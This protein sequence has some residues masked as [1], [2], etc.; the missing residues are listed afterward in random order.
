MDNVH[1][2]N[3]RDFLQFLQVT[4]WLLD[5]SPIEL[6]AASVLKTEGNMLTGIDQSFDGNDV[7]LASGKDG[8]ALS[9]IKSFMSLHFS[10]QIGELQVYK[11]SRGA[12]SSKPAEL[13][14]AGK[15][16]TKSR[17]SCM[18]WLESAKMI[19]LGL[20][21]GTVMVYHAETKITP[22]QF[23]QTWSVQVHR[24]PCTGIAVDLDQ[25]LLYTVS[26]GKR[27]R[28]LSLHDGSIINGSI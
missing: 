5:Y 12:G 10:P 13:I 19:C 3:D 28:T 6:T 25:Q 27:L 17:I 4:D 8:N 15:I 2:I 22:I 9:A 24:N 21:C 23:T 20:S 11:T 14:E 7:I 1:I 26:S 18:Y 16:E